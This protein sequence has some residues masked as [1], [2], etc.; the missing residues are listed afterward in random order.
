[1][2]ARSSAGAVGVWLFTRGAARK[3]MLT[4]GLD[5]LDPVAAA[6]SR[7]AETAYGSWDR[8]RWRSPRTTGIEGMRAARS[9]FG[10]DFPESWTGTTAARSDSRRR[11]TG[12]SSPPGDRRRPRR[13]SRGLV[14]TLRWRTIA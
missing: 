9:R 12:S 11:T 2:T 5:E 4:P 10:V 14:P 1:V 7:A 6:R 8:G 3:F 13:T